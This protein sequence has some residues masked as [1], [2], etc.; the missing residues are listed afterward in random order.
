MRRV[1]WWMVVAICSACGDDDAGV[2]AELDCNVL[3]EAVCDRLNVCGL[4][5]LEQC[6]ADVDGLFVCVGRTSA[7]LDACLDQVDAQTCVDVAG[8]APT[9][10]CSRFV[11]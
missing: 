2:S 7:E 11:P 1:T 8:D 6:R 5:E 4:V 3:E 9:P 10:A